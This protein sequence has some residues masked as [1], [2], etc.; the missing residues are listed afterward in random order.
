MLNLDSELTLGSSKKII[1]IIF[2]VNWVV[3]HSLKC[4]NNNNNIFFY[5]NHSLIENKKSPD[6]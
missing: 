3:D 4:K 2:Y 6:F 5:I 1:I